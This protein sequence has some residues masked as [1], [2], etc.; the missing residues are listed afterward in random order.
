MFKYSLYLSIGLCPGL[1][2]A[3]E[4][5]PTTPDR[6][7]QIRDAWLA[8]WKEQPY[9]SARF[10]RRSYD[11]KFEVEVLS[12]GQ[13]TWYDAKRWTYLAVPELVTP[14]LLKLREEP[15]AKVRRGKKGAP[16]KLKS[17]TFDVVHRIG[18]TMWFRDEP[19]WHQIK[20][21]PNSDPLKPRSF[22]EAL[23]F[24]VDVMFSCGPIAVFDPPTM[25]DR[26]EVE[27]VSEDP[28]ERTVRLRLRPV[29]DRWS[30]HWES[31][32]LILDTENWLPLHI[33]LRSPS[34]VHQEV[35]SFTNWTRKN[36]QVGETAQMS[37]GI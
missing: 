33:Q 7:V 36:A 31:V 24:G 22:L 19:D 16:Y 8:N 30:T 11:D 18:D 1:L 3:S 23:A 20:A 26:C 5:D 21:P 32:S 34:K 25:F 35:F 4:G 6:A 37:D 2:C 27:F 29:D 9:R 17:G 15:N 13:F 14:R 28:A 12:G 10:W